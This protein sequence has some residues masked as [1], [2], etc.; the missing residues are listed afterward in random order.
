MIETIFVYSLVFLLMLLLNYV[1][2]YIHDHNKVLCIGDRNNN[3]PI[4]ALLLFSFIFGIR[5]NVGI[6]YLRYLNNY[7]TIYA[8]RENIEIGFNFI[9]KIFTSLDFHF[10]FYF[11]FLAFLQVFLLFYALRNY[12]KIHSYLIIAFILSSTFLNFMNGIRQEIAFCFWVLAIT[13]IVKKKIFPYLICVLLAVSFHISAVILLPF[14]LIYRNRNCYFE[15]VKIQLLLLL[16]SLFIMF[17]FNPVLQI[18]ENLGKV[19]SFLGLGYDGYIRMVASGNLKFLEP[20]RERGI[21]FIVILCINVILICLSPKVKEY[22]K[23]PFLFIVYD[24]YFIG[25]L[26]LYLAAGSIALQRIN[27]YFQNFYF[28]VGAFTLYYLAKNSSM[29]NKLIHIS[30]LFLFF[31]VFFA[32]IIYRGEESGAIYSTF[33]QNN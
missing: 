1:S 31:L 4:L 32:I 2:V 8:R 26:Y 6:D 9:T 27:I 10:S 24:L 18:F 3:M 29:K 23:S 12:Y 14:F 16:V 7:E 20:S 15:N 28:I 5:Y 22:F 13:F 25:V 17:Y 11:T 19:S 21:G 33:W 30:L